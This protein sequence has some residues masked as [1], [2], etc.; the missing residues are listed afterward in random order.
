[1]KWGNVVATWG[2]VHAEG[3]GDILA[4]AGQAGAIIPNVN[5][6]Q[7]VVCVH[8]CVILLLGSCCTL[9]HAP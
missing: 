4:G 2:K 8:V 9:L 3:D 6:S 1:M 7:I 5:Q